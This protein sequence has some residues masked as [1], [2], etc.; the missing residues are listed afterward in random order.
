MIR[1]PVH[2]AELC[3]AVVHYCMRRKAEYPRSDG[4]WEPVIG[5][6]LA[7]GERPERED[8]GMG[9]KSKP[10]AEQKRAGCRVQRHHRE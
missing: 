8:P 1:T 2:T 3:S 9:E 10:T 4:I 5:W 6:P 7:E